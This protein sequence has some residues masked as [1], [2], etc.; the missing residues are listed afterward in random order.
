MDPYK[1]IKYLLGTEKAVRILES[2]NKLVCI[3]DKK[4]TKQQIKK[5]VEEAFKVKVIKL[6]TLVTPQGKKKA[7]ITLSAETPAIDVAT[8]LGLM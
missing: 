8:E 1:T 5:A 2:D 4:T 3:V 6:N 7:Y